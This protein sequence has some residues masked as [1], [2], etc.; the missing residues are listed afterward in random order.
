[1]AELRFDDRTAEFVDR[2]LPPAAVTERGHR[3]WTD[4]LFGAPVG[5]RPLALDIVVPAP[6]AGPYPVVV[7][8]HGG[9]WLF[10]HRATLNPILAGLRLFERLPAAGYGFASISYRFSGEATFPAQLHDAK[11]AVRWLRARAPTLDLDPDRVAAWGESAGGHLAALLGLTGDRPDLEGDVGVLGPSSSVQAVVDWYGPSD[12]LTMDEQAHPEATF[13]HDRPDAP[14]ALLIGGPVQEAAEAARAA[15]PVTYVHGGAP[16][17]LLQHGVDDRIVPAGQS[18][19][20]AAALTA[21]GADA[22]LQLLAGTDHVFADHPD[23]G[24]ILAAA[25]AFLDETIGRP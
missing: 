24:A 1:M 18:E 2:A 25:I 14:E 21:A 9:A 15:S 7:F 22:R 12:L 8:I 19:E 17:F 4:L 16:P 5:F 20:L 10:G 6:G 3:R 11:A 13:S 23:P